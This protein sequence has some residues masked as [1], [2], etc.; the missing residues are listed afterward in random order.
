MF[1]LIK[2]NKLLFWQPN[3]DW[4]KKISQK[5]YGNLFLVFFNYFLWFFLFYVSYCLIKQNINLFWQ[6][7]LATILSEIIEKTIKR[8]I[9]WCRPIHLRDN[10]IP[11][12]MIKS[13]Y[14]HGSFPSGHSIKI[15]FFFV[16]LL[17][18]P[19]SFSVLPYTI[20]T[21][22]LAVSRVVLGLHYPIDLIGGFVFGGILGMFIGQINFP[23]FLIEFIQ[24]I[25]NF[26]FFIK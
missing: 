19:T 11:S 5:K 24:P 23:L 1:K 3:I 4:F 2:E 17:K 8:R 12:G 14:Q 15:A 7:L 6:L 20:V 26:I 18:N 21:L 10:C 9:L 16:F 22:F 13:C 25:F